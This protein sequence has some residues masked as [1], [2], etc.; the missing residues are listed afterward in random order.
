M[1]LILASGSLWCEFRDSLVYIESSRTSG[2]TQINPLKKKK[3]LLVVYIRNEIQEQTGNPD[4]DFP[5]EGTCVFLLEELISG[6][7][8]GTQDN[9]VDFYSVLIL[10]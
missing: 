1:P 4:L 10:K 7:E 6:V 5:L 2:A 9:S 3:S 8:F